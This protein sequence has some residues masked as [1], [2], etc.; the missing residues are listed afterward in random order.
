[1]RKKAIF[2]L[3]TAFVLAVTSISAFA[4]DARK[5]KRVWKKSCRT[6]CHD[7]GNASDLSPVSKTQEQ[8]K[9]TF[10]NG[11][12][13]IHEAHK[14]KNVEVE[15]IPEIDWENIYEYLKNHA[16]DSDS[17]ETCG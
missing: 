3:L 4:A 15:A 1:M 9:E 10:A 13:K 5:G 2:A 11:Y 12:A 16:L 7:G 6:A 17:P 8:W 14:A